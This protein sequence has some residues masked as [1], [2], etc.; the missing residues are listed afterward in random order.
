MKGRRNLIIE[1]LMSGA[2]QL[3]YKSH[4]EFERAGHSTNKVNKGD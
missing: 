1:S 2:R 4:Q 3:T